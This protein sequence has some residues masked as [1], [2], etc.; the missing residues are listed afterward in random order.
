MSLLWPATLAAVLTLVLVPIARRYAHS[1][2]LIDHPG[3]RRS[4]DRPVARGGGIAVVIGLLAAFGAIWLQRAPDES[5]V[6]GLGILAAFAAGVGIVGLLG[7]WDDHRPLPVRVRLPVQLAVAAGLVIALGG[8]ASI[9][10]GAQALPGW[11]LWSL[12]AVP[13]VVW[14]M[15]LFNF[16]DGSDGLAALEA[17]VAGALLGWAFE[18]GGADLP[19]AVAFAVAGSAAGFLAWNRPPAR[20]FLGDAGSLTLGFVLGALALVG[21]ATATLPVAVAFIA[22]SPFVIDA[23]ATLVRRLVCGAGWY[24]PHR[25]HAYQCL[26]RSGW[27]HAQVLAALAV[28]NACVVVPAFVLAV[29]R[30]ESDGW[31]ALTTGVIL[32]A[33]WAAAGSRAQAEREDG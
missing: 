5:A 8:V 28:L 33:L 32:L 6:A 22:V 3:P 31:I 2:G 26:I 18:W 29:L 17:V 21:S 12:L 16:M 23:T 15:N 13:A 11:V 25:E 24:T 19:A 14:M 10:I 20:I 1:R 27:T 7:A 4:H 30:P 9:S